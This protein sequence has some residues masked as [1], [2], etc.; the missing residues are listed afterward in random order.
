MV[1]EEVLDPKA[2]SLSGV[3][4]VYGGSGDPFDC[5]L[6][7]Q[8]ATATDAPTAYLVTVPNVE[9]IEV[10]EDWETSTGVFTFDEDDL[11]SCIASQDDPA[12]RT[13]VLKLGHIDPRFDG[14]PTFGRIE[15]MRLSDNGQTLFG[16]IVGVPFWL[17]EIMATAYPRRSFEGAVQAKTRTGNTW[18]LT[19]TALSLLGATYPAI[20]TLEDLQQ[21]WGKEPPP[22]YPA[23]DTVEI[24]ATT[25]DLIQARKVDE[26]KWRRDKSGNAP[27]AAAPE[28]VGVK[29]KTKKVG[30]SSSLDDVRNA[31]YDMLGP[32]MMW[33]WIRSVLINP[34]QLIVD[35]DDGGLWMVDVNV[36]DDDT[37]TFGDPVAIKVEYVAATKA[38]ASVSA[39]GQ[40]VAASFADVKSAG[41]RARATVPPSGG[42]ATTEEAV[43]VQL[44]PEALAKIGLS[45]DATEDEINAALLALTNGSAGETAPAEPAAAPATAEPTATE[46][47]VPAPAAPAAPAAPEAVPEAPAAE[48]VPD[49]TPAQIAAAAAK[50]GLTLVDGDQWKAVQAGAQ[51][52][53]NL[54]AQQATQT[55]DSFIEAAVLAGKFP[56]ASMPKY[57]A[58]WDAEIKASGDAKDTKA[59]IDGLSGGLIPVEQR[60][61]AAE[62]DPAVAAAAAQYPDSW[63][64]S[65]AASAASNNT[66][67]VKVAND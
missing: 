26:V 63:K 36:G 35:D 59:L 60:G 44:T 51:A 4:Y 64:S 30:A 12:V 6:L 34:L 45:A 13:P 21:V 38:G 17:A 57:Q 20:D 43:E 31:F 23:D 14:Q 10:G 49:F 7:V 62:T 61:V 50:A 56:R 3:P 41:G 66:S 25:G 65:V 55:R 37:I 58:A 52:G 47:I 67:R 22:L 15:N 24:L 1:R 46:T 9:L 29:K 42:P 39:P 19:I 2:K 18:P 27:T 48:V 53:A 16:D 8:A 28:E 54:A 33:W 5:S 40:L 32:T 11:I